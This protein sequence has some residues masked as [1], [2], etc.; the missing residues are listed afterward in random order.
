GTSMPSRVFPSQAAVACPTGDRH[1]GA[2]LRWS[3]GSVYARL[4][5]A[6]WCVLLPIARSHGLG[7]E[8]DDP[9]ALRLIYAT[10]RIAAHQPTLYIESI[11]RGPRLTGSVTPRRS[12]HRPSGPSL[13]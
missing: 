13:S 10:L 7:A 9:Y 11:P 8:S 3:C 5:P 4:R 6:V 1:R 2:P 12:A